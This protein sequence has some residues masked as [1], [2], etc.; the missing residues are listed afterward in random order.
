MRTTTELTG[1]LNKDGCRAILILVR[2]VQQTGAVYHRDMVGETDIHPLYTV[3]LPSYCKSTL[4][5]TK[6][7]NLVKLTHNDNENK[8]GCGAIADNQ[9]PK[10]TK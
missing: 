10:D 1:R 9:W 3:H 6:K 8:T 5:C 4:K 7:T 2:T